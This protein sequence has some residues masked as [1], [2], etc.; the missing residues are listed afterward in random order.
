MV[1]RLRP[2]KC[3]N[4]GQIGPNSGPSPPVG[5]QPAIDQQTTAFLGTPC[6]GQ[7]PA[8]MVGTRGGTSAA[9]SEGRR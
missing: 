6:H 4:A 9:M 8:R 2:H 1:R 5:G 3:A 7:V